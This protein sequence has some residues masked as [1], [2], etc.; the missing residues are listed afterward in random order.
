MLQANPHSGP[1]RIPTPLPDPDSS[2]GWLAL[3]ATAMTSMLDK[4]GCKIDFSSTV[5][6]LTLG[7]VG[8]SFPN[9]YA[10]VITARQGE[11]DM[12]IA[13]VKEEGG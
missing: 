11:P 12:A 13:Q 7:A 8:T 4:I 9:L 2:L 6:G 10:S 3:L 1:R 5:M